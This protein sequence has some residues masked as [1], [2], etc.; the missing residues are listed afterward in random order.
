MFCTSALLAPGNGI[1]TLAIVTL[2][3]GS[4][5][6][7]VTS[8]ANS[9][10]SSATRASSGVSAWPGRRAARRPETPSGLA[11]HHVDSGQLATRSTAPQPAPRG[12]AGRP[13]GR[14]AVEAHLHRSAREQAAAISG[15]RSRRHSTVCDTGSAMGSSVREAGVTQRPSGSC[16]SLFSPHA[17]RQRRRATAPAPPRAA[18]RGRRAWPCRAAGVARSPASTCVASTMPSK[19]AVTAAEATRQCG[20][21]ARWPGPAALARLWR[22]ATASRRC[23]ARP[24]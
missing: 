3:C 1:S 20:L 17:P 5:S 15:G 18:R 22:R 21:R 2:I 6:R 4:S 7:G 23:Q 8:T 16:T 14:G 9:P 12:R 19:G 10:S 24:G 13:G 11:L